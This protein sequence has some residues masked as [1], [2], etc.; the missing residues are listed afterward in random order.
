[1]AWTVELGDS[2]RQRITETLQIATR[3]I[4]SW[5]S[6]QW[7]ESPPGDHGESAPESNRCRSSHVRDDPVVGGHDDVMWT[8]PCRRRRA[9]GN[10]SI[11][12]TAVS[13]RDR[14]RARVAGPGGVAVTVIPSESRRTF[15]CETSSPTTQ[16]AVLDGNR[17]TEPLR[18]RDDGRVDADDAAARVDQRAAGV[19]RD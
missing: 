19:S 14:A 12:S 8:K 1:M 7:T 4:P 2:R 13:E 18:H 3:P 16:A 17:K 15:P 11:T 6:N 5:Y 9:V 10:T